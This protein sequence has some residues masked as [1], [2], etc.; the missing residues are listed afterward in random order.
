MC[1]TLAPKLISISFVEQSPIIVPTTLQTSE[2]IKFRVN[3]S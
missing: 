1:V 2:A 3:S